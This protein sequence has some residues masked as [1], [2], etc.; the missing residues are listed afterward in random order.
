MKSFLLALFCTVSLCG[1]VIN[2][3]T[4]Y[5]EHQKG[6]TNLEAA[7]PPHLILYSGTP[8]MGKS[9]L[10]RA[11]AETFQ[12]VVISS[13]EARLLFR[14]YDYPRRLLNDY[15]VFAINKV[16]MT[17]SNGLIVLDNTI[18]SCFA[19]YEIYITHT[20][21][22][23]TLIRFVVP[24]EV[25]ISRLIQREADPQP[26]LDAL[27]GWWE[28]YENFGRDHA[29]DLIFNNTDQESALESLLDSL[30]ELLAQ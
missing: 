14:K 25:V 10:S 26:F 21:I 1:T 23:F 30:R 6:F 17:T 28:N 9:T 22:P 19:P 11:L 12:A 24:K 2:F 8:G 3:E 18:D 29:F 20:E 4:L 16:R 15:L 7:N 27:D 5:A 13:D